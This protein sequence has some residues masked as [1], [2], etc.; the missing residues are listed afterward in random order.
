MTDRRKFLKTAG[1][2]AASLGFFLTAQSAPQKRK[3]AFSTIGCPDWDLPRAANYAHSHGFQGIELR[4]VQ[5]ELDLTKANGFQHAAA[6]RS[7][8]RL[9]ADLSLDFVGFGASTRLHI[10]DGSERT[11]QLDEAKRFI[12]LAAELDCPY[13]RVFPDKLPKEQQK[14]ETLDRIVSGL[15]EL[16][17]YAGGSPVAVLLETHGDVVYTD[18]ILHIMQAVTHPHVGLLWDVFNMWV[19]TDETPAHAYRHLARYIR[20]V[21]L[22]DGKKGEKGPIHTMMGQGLAPISSAVQLLEAE[23]YSG[24]YSFEWEKLWHPELPE[25]EE[26]FADFVRFMK[27]C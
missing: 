9:M 16:G 17:E 22:K 27:T 26:A 19:A 6:R 11:K 18:N 13:V 21:H 15:R 1:L 7:T 24:Y 20:H 4:G 25:P 12:D 23:G 2:A 5:R 14:Q 10:Q 3:L 8:R